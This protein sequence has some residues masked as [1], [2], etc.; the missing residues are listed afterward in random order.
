MIITAGEVI[1]KS[2]LPETFTTGL[3]CK[4]LDKWEKLAF[5]NCLGYDLYNLLV[6]D[7][8]T[9]TTVTDWTDTTVLVDG[10]YYEFEEVVYLYTANETITGVDMPNCS[11]NWSIAQK[12]NTDCYNELWNN[13]LCDYL[14]NYIHLRVLPFTK[15][16]LYPNTSK[17][18]VSSFDN[19]LYS[20]DY[21]DIQRE[22]A[23]CLELLKCW[24]EDDNDDTTT[25]CD[26]SSVEF[27]NDDCNNCTDIEEGI[28]IG[29]LN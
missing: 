29:F 11:D 4:Y 25:T 8:F 7:L 17:N 23:E 2:H 6:D 28:R 12:F 14:A 26:W 18:S 15:K 10:D 1:L 13:G 3:I 24:I 16:T 20:Q 9:P 5:N 21:E 19:K 27:L 22:V